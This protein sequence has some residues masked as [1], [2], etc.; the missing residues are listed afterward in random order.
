MNDKLQELRKPF[1]DHQISYL[2]KGGTK[3]AYV[4]HAALTDRLLD[5]DPGWTWEPLA[6]SPHGLPVMD[7]LG[8]MW[9]RLTVC[10]VTRLGYGHAGSKQGGDAIKEII[11]D[12]LRNAAMRFGAALELW[13]KGDLHLDAVEI[14]DSSKAVLE[15][16]DATINALLD[17]IVCSNTIEQLKESF[18]IAIKTVGKNQIARDQIAQAKDAQKA[19]L[20]GTP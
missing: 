15:V 4:G 19:T 6:M 18:D 8:G 3:L 12:A 10:G 2:P 20:K 16:T 13:H 11:G 5:V 17:D 7:D 14:E 9:I 1:P